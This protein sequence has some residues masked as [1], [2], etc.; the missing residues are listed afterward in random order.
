[1]KII[2]VAKSLN[3][4]V[5]RCINRSC[6]KEVSLFFN[7]KIENLRLP[8]NDILLLFYK[9][10]ENGFEKDVCKNVQCCKGTYQ[11]IKRIALNFIGNLPDQQEKLGGDKKV[12]VDETVICHGPLEKSP[13]QLEDDFPGVTWLVGFIEENTRR[14]RY[15]IVENRSLDTFKRL[16]EEN[17]KIGTTVITDKHISYTGEV[18][19]VQGTHQVVD[20]SI[21]FKNTEGFHTNNIENLW[22]IMKYKIKKRRGILKQNIPSFS[23]EFDFRYRLLKNKIRNDIINV[24]SDII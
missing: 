24:F 9:W 20:Y 10:I 15:K 11:K 4:K 13:S 2:K 16:F 21:G 23:L 7:T 5:Y 6:Q 12:Q 19:H 14:I 1:M 17:I 22:S 8:I 18:S 3:G